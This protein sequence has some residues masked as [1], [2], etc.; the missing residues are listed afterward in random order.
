[1]QGI[2]GDYVIYSNYKGAGKC[3]IYFPSL[4]KF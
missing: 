1:M 2:N 3:Q 4:S